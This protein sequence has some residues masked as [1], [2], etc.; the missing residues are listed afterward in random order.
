VSDAY[1]IRAVKDVHSRYLS[2][3]EVS[4]SDSEVA[5]YNAI[6]GLIPTGITSAAIGTLD[7]KNNAAMDAMLTEFVATTKDE[8]RSTT[9]DRLARHIQWGDAV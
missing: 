9:L 2:T 7:L 3:G 1:I 8:K 5:I 6:K 4:G